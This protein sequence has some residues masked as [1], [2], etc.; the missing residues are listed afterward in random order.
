MNTSIKTGLDFGKRVS[1]KIRLCGL[2]LALKC[3]NLRDRYALSPC[4]VDLRGAVS[5]N[6][7]GFESYNLSLK[8]EV[9]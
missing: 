5:Q 4:E 6:G 3:L 8:L 1:K 9:L 2:A 7:V